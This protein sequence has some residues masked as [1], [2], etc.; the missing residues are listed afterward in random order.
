MFYKQQKKEEPVVELNDKQGTSTEEVEIIDRT[1]L[2]FGR[3]IVDEL[4]K[5][6][7]KCIELDKYGVPVNKKDWIHLD[8]INPNNFKDT[9]G[10]PDPLLLSPEIFFEIIK[11]RE[12]GCNKYPGDK[13]NWS[14]VASIEFIK[15]IWRHTMRILFFG[16]THDKESGLLHVSHIA[17]NAMFWLRKHLLIGEIKNG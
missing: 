7:P 14:G 1:N 9:A 6:E 2:D 4:T 8:A 13:D 11:V 16:E 5:P 17:C 10:K 15:A 12:Y 3:H